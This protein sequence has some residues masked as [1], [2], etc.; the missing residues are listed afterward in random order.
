VEHTPRR[1]CCGCRL[2]QQ[3]SKNDDITGT[4]RRGCASTNNVQRQQVCSYARG[5]IFVECGECGVE[6]S[7]AAAM[8]ALPRGGCTRRRGRW[9]TRHYCCPTATPCRRAQRVERVM[10]RGCCFPWEMCSSEA[11]RRRKARDGAAAVRGLL[12]ILSST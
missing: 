9:R 5:G 6:G 4:A 7:V 2:A 8:L 11:R 10:R 3:N 12:R 1:G